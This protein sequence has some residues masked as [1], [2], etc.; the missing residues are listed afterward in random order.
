MGYHCIKGLMHEKKIFGQFHGIYINVVFCKVIM[1]IVC[2][3]INSTY[4]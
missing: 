2:V 1:T 3:L 4:P